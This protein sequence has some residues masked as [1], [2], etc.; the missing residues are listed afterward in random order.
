VV[1]CYTEVSGSMHA[2]ETGFKQLVS[3]SVQ[4]QLLEAVTFNLQYK[5]AKCST[6]FQGRN[7][8]CMKLSVC[9]LL[10]TG[11]QSSSF[12]QLYIHVA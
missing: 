12:M 10:Y 5:K 9:V 3:Y 7:F 11:N 4:Q 2:E 8:S 6:E 1:V